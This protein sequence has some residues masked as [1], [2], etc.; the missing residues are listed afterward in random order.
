[1]S[2]TDLSKVHSIPFAIFGAGGGICAETD[3]SQALADR[4]LA[5]HDFTGKY[6]K[7]RILV[8]CPSVLL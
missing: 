2:V 1:M 4:N 5:F 3:F 7:W 8:T 6:G